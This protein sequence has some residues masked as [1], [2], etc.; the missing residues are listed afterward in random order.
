MVFRHYSFLINFY[1]KL[2]PK[3]HAASI[4]FV[5]T[6]K[7]PDYSQFLII[8]SLVFQFRWKQYWRLQILLRLIYHLISWSFFL[9]TRKLGCLLGCFSNPFSVFSFLLC[10]YLPH[11]GRE[12]WKFTSI[13][14][15]HQKTIFG[16]LFLVTFGLSLRASWFA[17]HSFGERLWREKEKTKQ[18][19]FSIDFCRNI[20]NVSKLCW[21]IDFSRNDNPSYEDLLISF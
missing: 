7:D 9:P 15:V 13:L 16:L 18:H 10:T 4:R 6:D 19:W 3:H 17:R 11:R 5:A 1:W 21:V 2:F 20:P 12:S 14:Q 8:S